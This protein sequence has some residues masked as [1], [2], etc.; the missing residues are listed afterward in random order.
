M[1]PLLDKLGQPEDIR[2]YSLFEL[3]SLAK[4]IRQLII[5]TVSQNW[6]P[7]WARWN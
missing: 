3:E 7:A 4:E 1:Y 5:A 6:L 2:K